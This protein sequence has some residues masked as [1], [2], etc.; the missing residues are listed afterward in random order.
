MAVTRTALAKVQED[1]LTR[2]L[3][4]RITED[5]AQRLD[6]E[7]SRRGVSRIETLRQ[8]LDGLAPRGDAPPPAPRR[9][10]ASAYHPG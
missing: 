8:L 4:L 5:Q 9:T 1:K 7:A 2:G 6:A 3:N 10:R